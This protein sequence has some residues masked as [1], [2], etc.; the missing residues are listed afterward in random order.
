ME[1]AWTSLAWPPSDPKLF[2]TSFYMSKDCL[3][4]D[5]KEMRYL[6]S[7]CCKSKTSI[8]NS[9]KLFLFKSIVLFPRAEAV[10]RSCSTSFSPSAI[11]EGAYWLFV[12]VAT[13]ESWRSLD[14]KKRR[15]TRGLKKAQLDPDLAAKRESNWTPAMKAKQT[16]LI[17]NLEFARSNIFQMVLCDY[18]RPAEEATHSKFGRIRMKHQ[19]LTSIRRSHAPLTDL[20]TMR[21][22]LD[23]K[24]RFCRI[25]DPFWFICDENS[26][27]KS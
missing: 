18:G 7:K 6:T 12:V 14:T 13:R 22:E 2:D 9:L 23:L 20:V 27:Q 1:S 10:L 21:F 4:Q 17:C 24:C 25:V 11:L 19:N 16:Q 5:K 8:G 3:I 15:V 26:Q